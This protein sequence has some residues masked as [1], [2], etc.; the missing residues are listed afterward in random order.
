MEAEEKEGRGQILDIFRKECW[1]H[2]LIVW[3][4]FVPFMS[5]GDDQTWVLQIYPKYIS[6]I[7][8]IWRK[9]TWKRNG[10]KI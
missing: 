9:N 1:Q 2:L 3:A 5:I 10:S 8:L 6:F 4:Y 7:F